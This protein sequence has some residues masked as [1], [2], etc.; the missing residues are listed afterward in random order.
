MILQVFRNNGTGVFAAGGE[1]PDRERRSPCFPVVADLNRDG[2]PT[3]P[4]VRLRAGSRCCSRDGAA[5]ICRRRAMASMGASVRPG[6]RRPERRR[7]HRS[8][9]AGRR[10]DTGV[11]HRRVPGRR[12]RQLRCRHG[13]LRR[14]RPRRAL[15]A[16]RRQRRRQARSGRPSSRLCE[17]VAVQ[18][19]QAGGTFAAPI[20]YP[21]PYSVNPATELDDD[22][23][24]RTSTAS[25]RSVTSTETASSTSPCRI[26][27]ARFSCSSAPAASR[28]VTCRC[29]S[30][31]RGSRLPRAHP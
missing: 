26:P 2:I 29:R 14:S 15:Q 28:P 9:R 16:G 30:G 8:D 19:G 27:Q 31:L 1:R 17:T 24:K 3:L 22:G 21:A 12:R 18:T 20:H 23:A 5:G 4:S 13:C 10:T 7:Q 11:Q 6:R 25:R